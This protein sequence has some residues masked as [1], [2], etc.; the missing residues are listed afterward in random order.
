MK[1]LKTERLS[2]SFGGVKALNS[3]NLEV[4]EGSIIG[5]LGPNGSGKSTLINVIS[6]VYPP[7]EGKISFK[8]RDITAMS[9]EKVSSLGL[10]RTFQVPRIFRSMTVLENMLVAEREQSG[11]R[12]RNIFL[13]WSQVKKEEERIREKALDILKFLEIESLADSLGENLSGGQQKLL[14]LGRAL[15]ADPQLLL[16]DEPIA[17]V[18]PRLAEKIFERILELRARGITFLIIEHNVEVLSRYVD[19]IYVM[20]R[21]EIVAKGKPK[22]ILESRELIEVYFGE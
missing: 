1:L 20:N 15:M 13:R 5:L 4:E 17:G 10:I 12:L 19:E 2:K 14:A 21:G 18:A 9:P 16:L 22:E 3:V 11:D 7:D 6:G 8:G